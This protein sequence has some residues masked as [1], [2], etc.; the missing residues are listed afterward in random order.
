MID[1]IDTAQ[2]F[3][4]ASRDFEKSPRAWNWQRLVVAMFAHQQAGQ[5]GNR[6]PSDI[7]DVRNLSEEEISERYERINKL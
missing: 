6:A 5:T 2:A 1:E 7:V 4:K 3:R